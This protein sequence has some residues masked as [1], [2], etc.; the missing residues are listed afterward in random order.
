VVVVTNDRLDFGRRE[1]IS[2]GE[3]GGCR[4]KWVLVKSR[5]HAVLP[6]GDLQSAALLSSAIVNRKYKP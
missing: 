5:R 6:K 3:F 2:C 1:R 4:R